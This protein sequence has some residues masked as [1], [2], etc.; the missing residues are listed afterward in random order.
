M[1]QNELLNL[2]FNTSS[3]CSGNIRIPF[4][5][6]SIKV[7]QMA[8]SSGSYTTG[9][10][11]SLHSDLVNQPLG[12]IYSVDTDSFLPISNMEYELSVPT[13]INQTYN[14]QLKSSNGAD[15]IPNTNTIISIILEFSSEY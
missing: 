3:I 15:F 1:K 5:V 11:L 14:F 2:V 12:I 10:F 7:K 8:F 6:R 9:E 4:E 13:F